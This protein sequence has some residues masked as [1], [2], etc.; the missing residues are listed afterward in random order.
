MGQILLHTEAATSGIA[1]LMWYR[2]E[3]VSF[4]SKDKS[5]SGV[6]IPVPAE[7][8]NKRALKEF[9]KL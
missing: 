7:L 5:E 6:V 9:D 8:A 1:H 4:P 2:A 3:I